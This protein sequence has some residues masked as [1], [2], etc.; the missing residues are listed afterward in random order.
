MID[1]IGYILYVYIRYAKARSPVSSQGKTGQN[2]PQALS[3]K[4][5]RDVPRA[6]RPAGGEGG[7]A[8]MQMHVAGYWILNTG[9]IRCLMRGTV[10][11]TLNLLNHGTWLVRGARALFPCLQLNSL[12]KAWKLKG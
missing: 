12:H 4:W 5:A 11:P 10:Q 3:L 7:P 8:G 1:L 9:Y 2:V 6:K